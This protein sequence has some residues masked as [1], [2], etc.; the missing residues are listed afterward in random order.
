MPDTK[1]Q[2][3][4]RYCGRRF[5][6]RDGALSGHGYRVSD[7][8]HQWLGYRD[9]HCCGQKL[10]AFELSPETGALL[11]DHLRQSLD[12]VVKSIKRLQDRPE[13][14]TVTVD[15]HKLGVP[16]AERLQTFEFH[17]DDE[18]GQHLP[19]GGYQTYERV[20]EG[21]LQEATSRRNH[22]QAA[23]CDVVAELK[24]WRPSNLRK[25]GR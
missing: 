20:R 13:K 5:L 10:Q 24:A 4:C 7:G 16:A 25:V 9:G 12:G 2:G 11:R 21:Q 14:L 18:Q 15:T 1:L 23:L 19:F 17:R 6:T 8:Y 3:T 22:L